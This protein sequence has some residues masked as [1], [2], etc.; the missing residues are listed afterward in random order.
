MG[1]DQTSTTASHDNADLSSDEEQLKSS[2]EQGRA[3]GVPWPYPR[4]V[5]YI[6]ARRRHVYQKVRKTGALRD[7]ARGSRAN[8]GC[9]EREVLGPKIKASCEEDDKELLGM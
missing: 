4:E 5:P 1:K 7:P 8:N 6:P 9:N 2:T 3:S